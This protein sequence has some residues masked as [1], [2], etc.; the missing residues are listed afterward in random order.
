[1]DL[2]A[3]YHEAFSNKVNVDEVKINSKDESKDFCL[4]NEKNER[5]EQ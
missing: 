3:R 2:L 5:A 4:S 1:M